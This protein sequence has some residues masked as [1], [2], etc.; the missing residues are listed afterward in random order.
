MLRFPLVTAVPQ[1]RKVVLHC[2]VESYLDC[3]EYIIALLYFPCYCSF[4]FQT[5][6]QLETVTLATDQLS[7]AW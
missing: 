6:I 1:N 3:L 5:T 2:A 4:F 7:P